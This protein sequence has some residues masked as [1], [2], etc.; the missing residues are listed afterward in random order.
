MT[1]AASSIIAL[2]P[3]L[4]NNFIPDHAQHSELFCDS[5]RSH[6]EPLAL[7]IRGRISEAV[8]TFIPEF[9][10]VQPLPAVRM[11]S[12]IGK[13]ESF[14]SASHR[15]RGWLD[16]LVKRSPE[17]ADEVCSSPG[18]VGSQAP[19]RRRLAPLSA[20][21]L[22]FLTSWLLFLFAS[23]A[24]GAALAASSASELVMGGANPGCYLAV[25]H[26]AIVNLEQ[27]DLTGL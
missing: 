1:E 2:R 5:L 15:T 17:E 7:S 8:S 27:H 22:T 13:L 25:A 3:Q 9:H 21:L 23:V 11:Y 12:S 10:Q 16:I 18:E 19:F 4:K 24:V 14:G 26:E 20:S 6:A